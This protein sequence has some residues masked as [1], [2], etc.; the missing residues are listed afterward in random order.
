MPENVSKIFLALGLALCVV[1]SIWLAVLRPAYLNYTY[2]GGVVFLEIMVVVLWKFQQ[3]FFP[4]LIV[5]FLLAGT[6]LPLRSVWI[7][8]R[9]LVLGIGA[10]SGYVMYL[11]GRHHSFGI[12]HMFASFAV[13]AALVSAIVSA[14][15]RVALLKVLSLFLLF[16]YAATGARVAVI[17]RE[18][19]F[20]RG[21][22]HSCEFMVYFSAVCYLI[23][24]IEIF[25]N[26]NSLGLIMGVVAAPVLLWGVFISQGT[27]TGTRRT[28]ALVLSLVLLFSSYARAGIAAGV[29]SCVLLC[30]A[31]R[32]YRLLIKG[33]GVAVLAAVLVATAIPVMPSFRE[34]QAPSFVSAFL[35]KGGSVGEIMQSRMT[36]WQNTTSVI[37]AHPWFGAGFGT[38]A[39]LSEATPGTF[40]STIAGTREHGNS[41]LAILE[42]VGLLGVI[43]FVVL[44][45]VL[46]VNLGRVWAW[47]HRTR[48]PFSPAIPL[49]AV[50]IAG[51]TH[52]TFEDW[53]FAVGSYMCVFFWVLAFVLIDILRSPAPL[54]VPVMSPDPSRPWAGNYGIATPSQ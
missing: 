46:I 38:S 48:S 20:F 22:L 28:F 26:P 29:V 49:A 8:L 41:Y 1:V 37:R 40:E 13:I 3:R 7:S 12:F 24:H 15:P 25:G 53:L 30:L 9:W 50:V 45:W 18:A 11:K 47:T 5:I 54:P 31:L 17:G 4:F 42:W 2:L 27:P 14:Y 43:P 33:A 39:T 10:I 6:M 19:K 36:P 34:G 51:L 16:A 23:V 21:L 32:Q 35:Y 44:L 52:A